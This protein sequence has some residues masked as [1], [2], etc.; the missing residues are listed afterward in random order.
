LGKVE[1][2]VVLVGVGEADEVVEY[3]SQA[4]RGEHADT[5]LDER[6]DVFGRGLAA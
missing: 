6:A 3:L 5:V 2:G 1:Y 4:D